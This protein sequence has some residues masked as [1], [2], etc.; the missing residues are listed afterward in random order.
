[1][2]DRA[3]AIRQKQNRALTR[4][5]VFIAEPVIRLDPSLSLKSNQ[6][7]LSGTTGSTNRTDI[8][9]QEL[10]QAIKSQQIKANLIVRLHPKNNP[11]DIYPLYEQMDSADAGGDPLELV[12][13]ADLVVG[14]TSMLMIEAYLAGANA[15]SIVPTVKEQNWL[16]Q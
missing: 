4:T 10:I 7:T 16:P 12:C 1:M 6:Y 11:N 15:L 13:Q 14:M 5:I 8:V 9:L 3:K 2:R